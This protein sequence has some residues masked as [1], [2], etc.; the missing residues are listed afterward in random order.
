MVGEPLVGFQI[1]QGAYQMFHDLGMR[2]PVGVIR[3][4]FF[5]GGRELRR[6][7]SQLNGAFEQFANVQTR[8]RRRSVHGMAK[9]RQRLEFLLQGFEQIHPPALPSLGLGLLF[10]HQSFVCRLEVSDELLLVGLRVVNQA[11][12]L[13]ELLLFQAGVDHVDGRPLLADKQHLLAAHHVIGNQIGD[14]LGFAGAGRSLNDVAGAL[15]RQANGG[16]LGWVAWHNVE[17][18]VQGQGR[19]RLGLHR[20]GHQREDGVEGRILHPIRRQF[21]VIPHQGH[22]AIAEVAQRQPAEIKLPVIRVV[23][24]LFTERIELTLALGRGHLVIRR[25]HVTPR[26]GL[27]L[28]DL[29]QTR[30]RGPN[31]SVENR[32]AQRME[33]RRII[34]VIHVQKVLHA[35]PR[36]PSAAPITV[37]TALGQVVDQV[38]PRTIHLGQA[39]PRFA[40]GDLGGQLV[41]DLVE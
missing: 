21:G 30:G 1:G 31:A 35:P 22:L 15:A 8:L 37:Q 33:V 26:R 9:G 18:F 32:Q 16:G 38:D 17:P 41:E 39:D 10:G 23:V 6:V 25:H 20:S 13:M 11:T 29:A 5:L 36:K 14:G 24:G 2:P 34:A 28:H 3:Q 27:L 19:S 40:G 4:R 12:K 7:F